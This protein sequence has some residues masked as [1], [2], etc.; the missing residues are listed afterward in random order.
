M[1]S[2]NEWHPSPRDLYSGPMALDHAA[3]YAAV[4]SRDARFDGIFFNGVKTTGI[5]CRPVCPART[6]KSENCTFFKTAAAAEAAGFR[7]CLRCR[8]ELSPW[9][10]DSYSGLAGQFVKDVQRDGLFGESL[11]STA[12]RLGVSSRHL[13]RTVEDECGVTPS[14]VVRTTRLLFARR[15]LSSTALPIARVAFGSGFNSLAR[16]NHSFHGHY[17]MAPSEFRKQTSKN[18]GSNGAIRLSLAYREPFA[19]EQILRYWSKRAIPGVESVSAGRYWRSVRMGDRRGWFSAGLGRDGMLDIRVSDDLATHLLPVAGRIRSMFDLDA[20]PAPIASVLSEDPAL[21]PMVEG[22]PGLRVPGAFDSFEIAV[23]AIL[24][25]QV[26]VAGASTLAGRLIQRFAT[27][28]AD[29]PAGLTHYPLQA[30]MLADVDVNEIA[31]IGMPS[32]RAASIR[33]LAQAVSSGSVS[34]DRP[35]AAAEALTEIPGIGNWTRDYIAVRVLRW[36]DAFPAG[37]LGLRKA[38]CPSS[39]L[40]ERA[41]EKRSQAWRPW[42][43]Y[44]ALYLWNSLSEKKI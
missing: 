17:G 13:R 30:E 25:Q 36:P 26:S 29:L 3:H 37:D 42:R 34:F 18:A 23:R 5:Y 22:T 2:E 7:P 11:E 39:A 38:L 16:F 41:L 9:A 6:P 15:L 35:S 32:T 4:Q 24:G 27:A 19:W 12:R 31:A 21:R 44:A 33:A 40:T 8:R 28:A 43:A 20:N 1:M 10:H 14:Q